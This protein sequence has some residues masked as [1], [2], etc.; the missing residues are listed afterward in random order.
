MCPSRLCN[1]LGAMSN[2]D[3][4]EVWRTLQQIA[5]CISVHMKTCISSLPKSTCEKKRLRRKWRKGSTLAI[6]GCSLPSSQTAGPTCR[7]VAPGRLDR[8]RRLT[9]HLTYICA[10]LHHHGAWLALRECHRRHLQVIQ[11]TEFSQEMDSGSG[12][13]TMRRRITGRDHSR[14]SDNRVCDPSVHSCSVRMRQP[15]CIAPPRCTR[16]PI[17]SRSRGTHHER[18]A[19]QVP[20]I[21]RRSRR[22]SSLRGAAIA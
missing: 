19:I 12:T 9:P 18:Y 5:A 1:G 6:R 7:R 2:V 3:R 11:L 14:K 10:R 4:V 17:P 8:I 15:Q 20:Q 16:I 22:M 21:C 13:R